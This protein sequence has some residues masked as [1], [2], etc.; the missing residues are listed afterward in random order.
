MGKHDFLAVT[1]LLLA[2]NNNKSITINLAVIWLFWAVLPLLVLNFTK[3]ALQ[4]T[5]CC[6][7]MIL[8]CLFFS[9]MLRLLSFHFDFLICT[10]L[11]QELFRT[12]FIYM[13]F[14]PEC[15]SQS[16]V[17]QYLGHVFWIVSALSRSLLCN[18]RVLAFEL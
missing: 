1:A 18:I 5:R 12:F 11:K 17:I 15:T 8:S 16:C 10:K 3:R 2:Q 14:L 9:V 13:M 4:V 7:Q 6:T